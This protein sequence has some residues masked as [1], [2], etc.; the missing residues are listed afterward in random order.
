MKKAETSNSTSS[1]RN[2][3]YICPSDKWSSVERLAI[4]DAL[5]NLEQGHQSYIYCIRDTFVDLEAKKHNIPRF[6]HQGKLSTKILKWNRFYDLAQEIRN[7]DINLVHCYDYKLVWPLSFFLRTNPIIS[8][9]LTCNQ[10]LQKYYDRIWHKALISRVDQVIVPY[11]RMAEDVRS[12]LRVPERKVEALG[13]GIQSSFSILET[14]ESG[15]F[16]IAVNIPPHEKDFSFLKT[17]FNALEALN[18]VQKERE[19]QLLLLN[20]QPWEETLIYQ[21]LKHYILDM[22]VANYIQF[23]GK[24]DIEKI[25]SQIHLW[26]QLNND[27]VVEDLSLKAIIKGLPILVPRSDFSMKVLKEFPSIGEI[28]KLGDSRELRDKILRILK[29]HQN[30]REY[31]KGR[32][33]DLLCEFGKDSYQEGLERVYQKVIKKRERY[34]RTHH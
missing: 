27:V 6:F 12:R 32:N 19:I 1:K 8:L 24:S 4:K 2:V 10:F 20:E 16:K 23:V 22:G 13:L 34:Y 33:E 14:N 21:E 18:S 29:G 17:I 3:L 30:Y 31:L 11:S 25:Q 7:R 28:Y 5:F 9:V 15:P 26:L